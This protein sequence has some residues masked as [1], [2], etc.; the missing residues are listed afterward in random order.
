MNS[1]TRISRKGGGDGVVWCGEGSFKLGPLELSLQ[2]DFQM[3]P[4]GQEDRLSVWGMMTLSR[5]VMT[6]SK[7]AVW[8]GT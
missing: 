5:I 1:D 8:A 4:L 6:M 7:G 2:Q 3:S